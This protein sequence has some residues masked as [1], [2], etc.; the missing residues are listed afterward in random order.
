V[1]EKTEI[2]HSRKTAYSAVAAMAV[3][4][5]TL[6]SSVYARRV[7]NTTEL[8]HFF[9]PFPAGK[10]VR[11]RV[12]DRPDGRK[13][14][15]QPLIIDVNERGL[16]KRIF[17]PGR[18]GVST[19][20]LVNIDTKPHRIGMTL[21]NVDVPLHWEVG[22]GIPWDPVSRTFQQAVAPGESVPD[23]GVDWIFEFPR[24]RREKNVWYEGELII[25]DADSGEKLTVFPLKFQSGRG[26]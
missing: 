1:V 8:V 22:A 13:I 18:E 7:L 24:E 10:V 20:W 25:F 26:E 3:A 15:I 14:F 21:T 19:H 9:I 4:A 6:G 12:V 16:L 2:K 11:P 17:N 23:L 5:L